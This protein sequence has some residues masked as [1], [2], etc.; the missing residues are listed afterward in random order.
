[1]TMN[2]YHFNE[3]KQDTWKCN[4]LIGIAYMIFGRGFIGED[5]DTKGSYFSVIRCARK[6]VMVLK[7][8][9]WDRHTT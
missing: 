4:W 3:H 8:S 2:K 6:S 5:I 7:T 9:I 1:M